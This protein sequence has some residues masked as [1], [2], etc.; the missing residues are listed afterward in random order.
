MND[1]TTLAT[2]IQVAI[3]ELPETESNGYR[4]RFVAPLTANFSANGE[5]PMSVTEYY[6][7]ICAAAGMNDGEGTCIHKLAVRRAWDE[8]LRKAASER[9]FRDAIAADDRAA[10]DYHDEMSDRRAVMAGVA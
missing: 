2:K 7:S 10:R 5:Y 6:C 8:A 4:I 3:S 9:R 1:L